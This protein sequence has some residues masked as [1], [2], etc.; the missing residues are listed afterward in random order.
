MRR[1]V[2]RILLLIAAMA[3]L[4]V[5]AAAAEVTLGGIRYN[6]NEVVG[7]VEANR[8]SITTAKRWPSP[9]LGTTRLMAVD[10]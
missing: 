4:T 5:G 9:K 8:P 6:G 1:F 10:S 3:A 2:G 7:P